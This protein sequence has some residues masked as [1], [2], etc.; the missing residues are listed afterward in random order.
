[1]KPIAL[2]V[3]LGVAAFCVFGFAATFEPLEQGQQFMWRTA[4]GAAGLASIACVVWI[5][6]KGFRTPLP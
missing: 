5:L 1:M 2:L 3:F 4:Y 6:A